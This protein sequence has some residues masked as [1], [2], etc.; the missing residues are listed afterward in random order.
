M[1]ALTNLSLIK[2]RI[3]NVEKKPPVKPI[4]GHGFSR[5][6]IEM[7]FVFKRLQL[8]APSHCVTVASRQA[9]NRFGKLGF[10]GR[11][12][13]SPELFEVIDANH[14]EFISLNAA[15]ETVAKIN[16]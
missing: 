14:A 16:L 12:Y 13:V 2:T 4:K 9:I 8:L 7:D 15:L 6:E 10:V 3:A 1:K 11:T 5:H